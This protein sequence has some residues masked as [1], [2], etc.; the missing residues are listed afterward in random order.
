MLARAG[1][2]RSVS[3]D[4]ASSTCWPCCLAV[5]ARAKKAS[6]LT[7]SVDCWRGSSKMTNPGGFVSVCLAISRRPSRYG[8]IS[9]IPFEAEMPNPTSAPLRLR[10]YVSSEISMSAGLK[11]R[12]P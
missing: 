5:A 1:S 4:V 12:N 2:R 11:L 7:G 8:Q 3:S 9:R 10:R 6:R